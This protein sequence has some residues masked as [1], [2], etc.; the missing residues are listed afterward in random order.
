MKQ[1]VFTAVRLQ[2]GL[3]RFVVMNMNEPMV[4]KE[5]AWILGSLS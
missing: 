4:R 1:E 3:Q 5:I 2:K